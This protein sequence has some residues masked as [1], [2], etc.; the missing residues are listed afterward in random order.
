MK[1]LA[2]FMLFVSVALSAAEQ[3][4]FKAKSMKDWAGALRKV[5]CKDG[6][7]DT[8]KD[9]FVLISR[10][11]IKVTPGKTYRIYGDFKL[12]L[13]CPLGNIRF[14]IIPVDASG[15]ELKRQYIGASPFNDRVAGNNHNQ[16][17]NFWLTFEGKIPDGKFQFPEGTVA[18][19]VILHQLEDYIVDMNFKN[20]KVTEE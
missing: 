11:K 20:I 18:F 17:R 8:N 1:Y 14:G 10:T 6:L 16:V 9:Q 2:I 13:Y 3:V 12:K 5:S 4:V 15:K 7:F 19:K